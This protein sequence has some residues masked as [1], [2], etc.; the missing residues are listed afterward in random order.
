MSD[1]PSLHLSLD[2]ALERVGVDPVRHACF[3]AASD[4]LHEA[5]QSHSLAWLM[6]PSGVGK[7]LL[8]QTFVREVSE[9]DRCDR[10]PI[11]AL[12]VTAPAAHRG[13]FSWKDFF[14]SVLCALHD[15]LPDCKVDHVATAEALARGAV[16]R[17]A[18]STEATLER[19]VCLAARDNGLRY[20][21]VDEALAFVQAG[22][23]R[24]LRHQLDVLRNLA[25]N[26]RISLVLI[27]TPR[28]LAGRD[29]SPELARRTTDIVFP[30]YVCA[31]DRRRSELRAFGRAV[32]TFFRMFPDEV[33][34]RPTA[35]HVRHLHAGSLGCVGLLSQWIRR[36]VRHC[37]AREEPP[38][39]WSHFE[40]TVMPDA[41]RAMLL[42]EFRRHEANVAAA[43]ART[44]PHAPPD[45][46]A[47]ADPSASS[48]ISPTAQSPGRARARP[49]SGRRRGIPAPTRAA[50]G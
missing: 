21:L 5:L 18:R 41:K 47:P 25:D 34:F 38:L 12:L 20:L 17:S 4:D 9:R 35:G 30:R 14:I 27:S 42:E 49:A 37:L 46:L 3:Q 8:A 29:L 13:V 19:A 16:L 11:P 32:T 15:P 10:A 48:D 23:A 7:S 50:V 44:F 2:S 31:G 1:D 40:R 33:A 39:A 45:V 26:G 36:A 22:R 24:G 6:G 28:I 43:T